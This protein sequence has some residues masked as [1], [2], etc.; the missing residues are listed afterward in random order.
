MKGDQMDKKTVLFIEDE[1]DDINFVLNAVKENKA[2]IN[3]IIIGYNGK[4]ALR[5]LNL[6]NKSERKN[7]A[8]YPDLIILD[9]KL[10]EIGG[11]EVLRKIKN[12]KNT[13]NIPVVIFTSSDDT[14]E[15]K[16]S[17]EMGVNSFV[18]KPIIYEEFIDTV[19]KIIDYWV[20]VN[21][22]LPIQK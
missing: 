14:A 1:I 22:S 17:Y 12:D 3:Y 11:I 6:D 9:L 19:K 7:I 21:Q 4:E 20:E 13:K 2:F 8:F 5:Y 16:S 18:K 15:L 10:P